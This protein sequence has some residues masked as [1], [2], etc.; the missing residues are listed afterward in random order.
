MHKFQFQNTAEMTE[1]MLAEVKNADRG[2]T[3]SEVLYMLSP[4][5]YLTY[6][7]N[8]LF[9]LQSPSMYEY[10]KRSNQ[11]YFKQGGKD[12]GKEIEI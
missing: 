11:K 7:Q 2:F 12:S 10:Y 4:G 8:R 9:G 3:Q 1:L 5:Q 6:T